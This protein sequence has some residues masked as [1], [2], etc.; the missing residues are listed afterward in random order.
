MPE[1]AQEG[2]FKSITH[3][4]YKQCV[5]VCSTKHSEYSVVCVAL[6][7]A[8]SSAMFCLM[9]YVAM[10]HHTRDLHTIRYKERLLGHRP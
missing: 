6:G 4:N 1:K 7:F 8:N 10:P 9:D 3:A 5:E 2:H